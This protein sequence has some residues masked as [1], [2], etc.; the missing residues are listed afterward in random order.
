MR[1]YW[2]KL[3][4]I[5]L[6][7]YTFAYGLLVPIPEIAKNSNLEE[8][9]RNVFFHVP[10]WFGMILLL[11]ISAVYSILYLRNS[12]PYHDL[13]AV[14]CINVG[15]LFG[16]LG[17]ATGSLWANYTWNDPWPNDPKLNGVAIGMLIYAAYIILRNGIEDPQK[18]ARV[19]AVYNVFSW[20]IFIVLIGILPRINDS[21]HPGNGGNP[22][23]GKYDLDDQLKQ[24][25]YPA[26]LGWMLLSVW[27][28]SLSVRMNKLEDSPGPQK[29]N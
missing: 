25:F 13:V 2:W 23:F 5:M 29:N 12:N 22:A 11:T 19:S 1:K 20:P 17:A 15:M 27:L 4:A 24:V 3:L 9:I 28:M 21:L 7:L 18:K 10:M 26:C 16:V 14:E 6:L 8:T